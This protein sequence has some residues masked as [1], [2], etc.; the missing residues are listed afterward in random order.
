MKILLYG[1]NFAPEP[2]GIGKYSGE[3]AAWLAAAGNEVRVISA[4]PYYPTWRIGEGY[5]AWRSVQERWQGVRVWRTPLWIPSKPSGSKRVLHLA[6]FAVLSL[7]ALVRQIFW[8]P[9]V[10]VV[11]APAL[12]CAPG[13]WLAARVCGASAWLHIQDFEVDA[14]FRLGLLK[15]RIAQAATSLVERWLLRRFDRVSTISGR[16]LDLLRAK[17]VDPARTALFPNWVDV[18][19]IMPMRQVSPYRAELNIP[20]DAVVALYSGSMAGKQGLELLPAAARMLRERLPNLVFV[21]CGDGVFKPSIERD[22]ADLPNV[23]LLPLQPSS[24]LGELLGMADVHLL[25]QH[26]KAADLV[27]PSK[28]TGMLSSGRPVLATAHPGTELA[29]VVAGCGVVVPPNDLQAFVEALSR[30]AAS[31]E[32]RAQLGQA[33]RCYAESNL[34]RD[35]VLVDFELALK[36]CVGE[37]GFARPDAVAIP[38]TTAPDENAKAT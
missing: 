23:R 1:L 5:S 26:E 12:A 20:A 25:P 19:A 31:P 13:G 11:V 35:R 10:I 3:M 22:C 27:M 4:P 28:L 17:H 36:R 9:D 32:L 34:A 2:T 15:G 33:A 7:P 8:K 30:L 24:R 37:A 21:L 16:M 18:S 14:A 29:T 38:T 6:S